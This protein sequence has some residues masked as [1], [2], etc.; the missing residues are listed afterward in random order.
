MASPFRLNKKARKRW[1]KSEKRAAILAEKFGREGTK[2]EFVPGLRWSVDFCNR[3]AVA[4]RR[5]KKSK[6]SH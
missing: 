3:W 2:S 6:K 4:K 5:K 1:R